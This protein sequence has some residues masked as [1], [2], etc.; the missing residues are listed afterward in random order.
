MTALVLLLLSWYLAFGKTYRLIGGYRQLNARM[1]AG[2]A[3]ANTA[4]LRERLSTQDSLL[5]LYTAD[6]TSWVSGLLVQVGEVLDGQPLG[7]SFENKA[8]GTTTDI[9][10]REVTLQGSFTALQQALEA[11]EERFFVKSIQA[12]VE[13]EQLRYKVKLAAVKAARD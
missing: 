2:G 8:M 4:M 11:L 5:T 13:K 10:E 1:S 3:M 7:V 9:V 6:S 12:Y